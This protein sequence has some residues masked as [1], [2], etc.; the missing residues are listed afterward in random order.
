MTTAPRPNPIA[1]T[2][3]AGPLPALYVPPT[4][5]SPGPFALLWHTVIA[6]AHRTGG[7][8]RVRNP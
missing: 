5:H 2:P 4:P 7:T 6:A 1:V 3:A 8:F